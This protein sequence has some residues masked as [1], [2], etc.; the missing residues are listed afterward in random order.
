MGWLGKLVGKIVLRAQSRSEIEYQLPFVCPQEETNLDALSA[1]YYWVNHNGK[2]PLRRVESIEFLKLDEKWCEGHLL[3]P[4]N[5]EQF[6][7]KARLRAQFVRTN[8]N[9]YYVYSAAHG[10]RRCEPLNLD[11]K[12]LRQF[13]L[14]MGS[15]DYLRLSAQKVQTIKRK[16]CPDLKLNLN[17]YNTNIDLEEVKEFKKIPDV[18]SVS[19]TD[20]ELIALQQKK[21]TVRRYFVP[22]NDG[23]ELDT[24]CIE[25]ND[26]NKS[27]TEK[28]YIINFC[29]NMGSC[30]DSISDRTTEANAGY[31]AISFNYRG[32]LGSADKNHPC[33]SKQ[34]LIDDGITQVQALLD[35]NV[36]PDNINLSGISLGGAIAIEVAAHFHRKGTPI[37]VFADRTFSSLQT[38]VNSYASMLA[39]TLLNPFSRLFYRTPFL[40]IVAKIIFWPLSLLLIGLAYPIASFALQISDWNLNPGKAVQDIPEQN[41][42]YFVAK[43]PKSKRQNLFDGHIDDEVIPYSASLYK[44]P[45]LKQERRNQKNEVNATTATDSKKSKYRKFFAQDKQNTHNMEL[46]KLKNTYDETGFEVRM[47]FFNRNIEKEDDTILMGAAHDFDYDSDSDSSYSQ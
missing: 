31:T 5:V 1:R 33:E 43:T 41:R 19:P 2:K 40:A 25:S 12:S 39:N 8:D 47:H 18:S 22:T 21:Y 7:E 36:N 15:N 17:Y 9:V 35:K 32:V 20:L 46:W 13:D 11:K 37:R 28:R 14:E 27:D 23:A 38:L 16:F 24:L 6:Y 34:H 10:Q 30:F 4:K 29:G 42:E 45:F 44:H 3:D 26:A